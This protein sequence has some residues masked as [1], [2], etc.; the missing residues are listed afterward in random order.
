MLYRLLTLPLLFLAIMPICNA[1]SG[2]L[3]Q[4]SGTSANLYGVHFIDSNNG[5]AVGDGGTLIRTTD[6]GITWSAVSLGVTKNLRDIDFGDKLHG[7]IV[8]DSTTIFTTDDGG[9]TWTP[10]TPTLKKPVDL[11]DVDF[12]N[13]SLGAASGAKAILHTTDGGKNWVS[14]APNSSNSFISVAV[15]SP[16]TMIAVSQPN[17]KESSLIVK[18]RGDELWSSYGGNPLRIFF[19]DNRHGWYTGLSQ[20]ISYTKDGGRS[21]ETRGYGT[22]RS[23]SPMMKNIFFVDTLYGWSVGD[24]GIIYH[25]QG[26]PFDWHHQYSGT[27]ANLRALYFTDRNN[28]WIVGDRGTILHTPDGG[29]SVAA[30]TLLIDGFEESIN[31]W[32]IQDRLNDGA[33]WEHSLDAGSAHTGNGTMRMTNTTGIY[34]W[35]GLVTPAIDIPPGKLATLSFWMKA[36]NSPAVTDP[37]NSKFEV[38][39]STA[40]PS[41]TAFHAAP[42]YYMNFPTEWTLFHADLR[43]FTGQRIWVRWLFRQEKTMTLNLDDVLLIAFGKG[44]SP[45]AVPHAGNAPAALSLFMIYPSPAAS[46]TTIEYMLDAP[47]RVRGS[48][49]NSYGN[50]VAR[51]IDADEEAGTARH[52]IDLHG[53]PAGMY[54][55]RLQIGDRTEVRAIVVR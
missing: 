55:C 17:A 33:M 32:T 8:G 35:E 51:I 11:V 30:D 31:G 1:Q 40:G 15:P 2:W 5:F 34:R 42:A 25:S 16:D 48:I 12:Y 9:T 39:V 44:G 22:W 19:L 4:N 49:I 54:Y 26:Q 53:L 3:P 21:W 6:G 14:V 47:S 13:G 28:G 46:G 18:V 50:E 23:P 27:S 10:R 41:D 43:P 45:A 24:S 29:I 37:A 7:C 52:H 36:D 38:Q 20:S